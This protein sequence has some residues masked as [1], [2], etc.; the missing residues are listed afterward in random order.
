MNKT[1]QQD[2][3]QPLL[4][5]IVEGIPI[6]VFWKDR[7]SRFLGCNSLF[8]RDAG[9][10]RPDELIGKTD[11]ELGWKDQAKLYRADDVRVMK[12]GA[13]RLGYIEFQTTLHGKTTWLRTS[14][15]PLR[16]ATQKV[17]G[18]LG[19]YEDITLQKQAEEALRESQERLDLALR[20]AR[21]GVWQWDIVENKRHFD[22]QVCYLVGID[23]ATFT[24][25]E[26]QF[27]GAIH[28][29]DRA[30]IKAS[31]DRT[32]EQDLPYEPEYRAV[33]P[34]G[35]IRHLTARGRVTRDDNGRPIRVNGI[36]WDITDRKGVEANLRIA[37]IAFESQ[38][39]MMITDAM[40]VILRVNQAFSKMTGYSADE[41]VGQTARLLKSNRHDETFYAAM[42]ERIQ[43][44]GVW[45][46][47]VW[48]RRKNG[49]VFPTW[50]TMT[51]V[52]GG[53]G[54]NTHY[55]SMQTDISQ[56]KAADE[57]IQHLA[58]YDSLTS[59][60]N[61]RLLLDRLHQAQASSARRK[62]SGAILFIDLDSFK[63]INDTL[64]H[65]AGDLLLLQV[66]QRLTTCTRDVDTV[67]RIGGAEFV[68]MQAGLGGH[69]QEAATVARIGGDEF[70]V[71]LEDLSERAQ[72]AATQAEIVGERIKS[73]LNQPY[74]LTGQEYLSTSSI[75]VTVFYDPRESADDLLK[76][77]D[78]AM[79]QAKAMGRNAMR[80]FDPDMQAAVTLRA[81]LEIDLREAIRKKQFILHF[82]A[83][84]DSTGRLT[85][86][87]ALV[88]WQHPRRGTVFPNEFIPLAEE[89]G[90]ILPLGHWVLETAC[91]QLVAWAARTETAGLTLA[92][93]VS[94]RQFRHPDFVEQ[95]QGLLGRLDANPLKLKLELTESLLLDNVDDTITK[96]TTLKAMGIGFSLD[97]FGT[98]YSSL[99][100]LK[101]L[102][103]D[104]LKIDQSFVRDV[105][106]DPN[107]AAIARTIVALGQSLGLAVIAEGVETEDQRSFLAQLGCNAYQ[108][109]LFSKPLRL[110]EFE[111]FLN[112]SCARF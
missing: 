8:A 40:G 109:Y 51:A 83:Q 48:D 2:S 92:V 36:I 44:D 52:K 108:G 105:L 71:L 14:K 110:E 57:Q 37:A 90:L 18:V 91:A 1:L 25:A 33:W 11:S 87:E 89:T 59:L 47:E 35:S 42:W 19:S 21:M 20:S 55:V 64:G 34:D 58:F 86:A 77:A 73:A 39:G 32:I 101:R 17:V 93:N 63:N 66:A 9:L 49:D 38:E 65:D 54:E 15:V 70:V 94:A 30:V 69:T 111:Q 100:Y 80:F 50:L 88:R 75:G 60:P 4:Q 98:G 62:R 6:R 56:R 3:F 46:G 41:A 28:P 79:Y 53:D 12:Q 78:L 16:D 85:G 104:Q 23:P 82:Q 72:E 112:R 61:R 31:L 26:E 13:P 84:V 81:N 99:S 5:D 43:R 27:F 103:L 106:T 95:V 29:D 74:Q 68:A 76:Q 97:D 24:G 107:D 102:P 10:T 67:A 22:D 96:M 45:Q 7:D